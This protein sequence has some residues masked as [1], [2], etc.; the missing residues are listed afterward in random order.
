M[1][2]TTPTS[3]ILKKISVLYVEDERMLARMMEEAIGRHFRRFR[4]AHDGEEGLELFHRDKPDLLITDITMPRMDGLTLAEKIRA[5]SPATPV[6]ILSAYSEKEKLLRAIEIGIRKYFIKPFDPDELLDYLRELGQ[7]LYRDA[8]FF[9]AGDFRYDRMERRLCN[10]EGKEIPLT[11]RELAFIDALIDEPGHR[12]DGKTL[13]QLLWDNDASP[14]ALRVFV[15]R[16]RAKT[17]KD[18]V[19]RTKDR[20]YGILVR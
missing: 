12:L 14:E 3:D 11:A 18:F 10:R 13:R 19:I 4:V 9:I 16:L 20:G 8:R 17:S 5:V 1:R 6:I 7:A 2:E 15:M